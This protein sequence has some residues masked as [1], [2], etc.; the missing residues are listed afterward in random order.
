MESWGSSVQSNGFR[1]QH[2]DEQGKQPNDVWTECN[3]AHAIGLT[4]FKI[5]MQDDFGVWGQASLQVG[6]SWKMAAAMFH[7]VWRP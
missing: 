7:A 1:Q 4:D 2:Q 3:G 6:L 5:S